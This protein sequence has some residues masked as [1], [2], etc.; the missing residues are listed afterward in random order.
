MSSTKLP[1]RNVVPAKRA[2][3]TNGLTAPRM[4][5]GPTQPFTDAQR[6]G[7]LKDMREPPPVAAVF[8]D[9]LEMEIEVETDETA[10][11]AKKAT[12]TNAHVSPR[13]TK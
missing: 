11:P 12:S 8:D 4:R 9:D 6:R 5:P 10:A 1:S 3:T 13:R 7:L 2:A